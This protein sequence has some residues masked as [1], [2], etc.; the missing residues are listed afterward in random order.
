MNEKRWIPPQDETELNMPPLKKE[1]IINIVPAHLL[2]CLALLRDHIPVCV[3][4]KESQEDPLQN[5][6]IICRVWNTHKNKTAY[7][8]T[9]NQLKKQN[10]TNVCCLQIPLPICILYRKEAKYRNNLLLRLL[11]NTA[12]FSLELSSI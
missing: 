3:I 12:V 11:P 9:W 7:S 10:K 4:A 1:K 8:A 5:R 2:Y 6:V